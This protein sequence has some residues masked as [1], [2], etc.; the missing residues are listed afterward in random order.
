MCRRPPPPYRRLQ[1]VVPAIS[2]TIA[3]PSGA[4]EQSAAHRFS[5][6]RISITAGGDHS[7]ALL[8]QGGLVVCWG[9]GDYGQ[10]VPPRSLVSFVQIAAGEDHTVAIDS[11]GTVVCWGRNHD[12]QC[13]VPAGMGK[14]VAVGAGK[15]HTVA[16]TSDGLL[17]A[18]GL[19]R[20]GQ[21]T[22]PKDLAGAAEVACGEYHNLVRL[23]GGSVRGWG[24]DSFGQATPPP[25][26]QGCVQLSAGQSHSAAL[27]DD[28]SVV[29]W[30]RDNEGQRTVPEG[31]PPCSAI[32]CG[33]QHTLALVRETG[34]VV[35]WG[36]DA[37]GQATPPPG[38]PAI[39]S[40]AAGRAHSVAVTNGGRVAVWGQRERRQASI[41]PQLGPYVRLEASTAP[42]RS[43]PMIGALRDDGLL[44]LWWLNHRHAT[45]SLEISGHAVDPHDFGPIV[46]FA[47]G[48]EGFV[49]AVRRDGSVV[50]AGNRKGDPRLSIPRDIEGTV[51]LSV[52]TGHVLALLAD[53]RVL[54]WGDASEGQCTVPAGLT[55]VRQI[56]A[57]KEGSVA[58]TGDGQVHAWGAARFPSKDAPFPIARLA[59]IPES[60]V[61]YAIS[62]DHGVHVA[63]PMR[64]GRQVDWTWR[65]LI[66]PDADD[67]QP[68]L[69]RLPSPE[70]AAFA[71]P[72][73]D[74]NLVLGP[75][76]N[77]LVLPKSDASRSSRIGVPGSIG[78]CVQVLS[79]RTYLP[80]LLRSDGSAAWWH[81]TAE[82]DWQARGS[83]P[84]EIADGSRRGTPT[85]KAEPA[86]PRR[87]SR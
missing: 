41:P 71:A 44:E 70:T 87:K 5:G 1:V 39:R 32:A 24:H 30:G 35:G 31:L 18:W 29:C 64:R 82:S 59:N 85:R 42:W 58:L 28:G 38:L 17:R 62:T 11:N 25:G 79:N 53:G 77:L 61:W 37:D 68:G 3:L 80:V 16:I 10:C 57:V 34:R 47:V 67:K 55:D 76:G 33:A 4:A 19:N 81:G 7:V 46:T 20:S 60:D 74:A 72:Y 84:D 9:R 27:L 26:L 12:G 51:Q 56:I 23:R 2:L 50:A 83:H 63:K 49:I 8:K 73:G 52:G 54:A 36:L 66:P 22:V 75:E 48:D 6:D 14:C 65:V 78:A 40:I 69:G 43:N 15:A 45:K 13:T 86:A 21:A